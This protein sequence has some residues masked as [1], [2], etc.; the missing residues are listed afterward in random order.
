MVGRENCLVHRNEAGINLVSYTMKFS[1][2]GEA[3]VLMEKWERSVLDINTM[4]SLRWEWN[5]KVCHSATHFLSHV[6]RARTQSRSSTNAV[7][8][9]CRSISVT[10]Q[11]QLKI[12]ACRKLASDGVISLVE[13]LNK[14]VVS[15][16]ASDRQG[17]CLESCVWRAASFH[18]SHHSQEV[19]LAQFS[20][21]V[22]KGGL[23]LIYFISVFD[24]CCNSLTRKI[25]VEEE[26]DEIGGGGVGNNE[27]LDFL[28]II[29]LSYMQ[30]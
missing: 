14:R 7:V 3:H 12:L 30:F 13:S 20:L 15:C 1:E 9:D 16:S 17:Y 2:K 6:E 23:K 26:E 8:E 21:Y 19:S 4:L 27:L 22:H 28:Y 18:S 5:T 29:N 11:K 25:R 10:D 24:D